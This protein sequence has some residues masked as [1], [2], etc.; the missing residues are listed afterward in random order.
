MSLAADI[1]FART[2]PAHPVTITHE[3]GQ[4][5]EYAWACPPECTTRPCQMLD[6]LRLADWI[7]LAEH[8]PVGQY[9]AVP[10]LTTVRL[11]CLD[12]SDVPPVP[13]KPLDLDD[14]VLDV[15][16]E[17]GNR[18]VADQTHAD[19]CGCDDWPEKCRHYPAGTWD[20]GAWQAGLPTVLA[21]WEQLRPR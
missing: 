3:P 18:A 15:L 17:A 12:G 13:I 11:T 7:T 4:D 14:E 21:L 6:R 19:M 2:T 5:R 10:N 1:A 20:T 8:L 16:A 9:L